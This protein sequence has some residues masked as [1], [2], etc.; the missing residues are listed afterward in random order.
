MERIII[1]DDNNC[2]KELADFLEANKEHI[3]FNSSLDDFKTTSKG[4]FEELVAE[5]EMEDRLAIDSNRQIDIIHTRDITYIE[6][7]GPR[8]ALH[9]ENN[10]CI[11]TG[12]SIDG[13]EK[14]LIGHHFIRI[15]DNYMINTDY[16]SKLNLGNNP[17]AVLKNGA[18]LPVNPAEINRLITY[19]NSIAT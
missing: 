13:Y 9:F 1:I 12:C 17:A 6:A 11:E 16:F 4:I 18:V 8:T 2:K 7:L 5:V 19:I 15:H 3:R 14:K 10:N